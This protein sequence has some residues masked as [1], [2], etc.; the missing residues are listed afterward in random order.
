MKQELSV[1]AGGLS[2]G[3]AVGAL[4]WVAIDAMLVDRNAVGLG[5]SAAIGL[6]VAYIWVAN[7][8]KRRAWRAGEAAAQLP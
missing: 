5:V 4:L 3:A 7:V 2:I 8:K 1:W 6:G